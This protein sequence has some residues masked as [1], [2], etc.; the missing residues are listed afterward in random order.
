MFQTLLLLLNL[1]CGVLMVTDDPGAEDPS[2]ATEL[3]QD[4]V[5]AAIQKAIPLLQQGASVSAKERKC[6][7]CHNQALPVI[8]LTE[9]AKRGF[10][11]DREI[12]Q[13]QLQHTWDHLEKGKAEYHAGKGQ[14]GQVMTAGYAMW[15]LEAGAWEADET[16]AAVCHYLVEY[17]KD[18]NR[19]LPSSQRLPSMGSSFTATYVALRAL[20]HYGTSEQADSIK[21]RRDAAAKW[22]LENLPQ[23]NED[24]VFRLRTLPY[25]NAAEDAIQKDVEALL[26]IQQTDGGWSQ[27]D[28][29]TSDAYA[30]GTVLTALQEVGRLPVS[31]PAIVSG[32]R[33]LIDSQLEDGTW[34]V[35]THAKPIQTYY[36]S[37]FPHGPDQFISI[38]A[39]AW[40][41]LALAGTLPETT[42]AAEP[43]LIEVRRIWDRA[44]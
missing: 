6:F 25:L 12:L 33:Y 27:T 18:Q 37:G 13:R 17:H 34:H 36:E 26:A 22:F 40:A 5:R 43:E 42:G 19:W 2:P 24:R 15:A 21:A 38:T 9:F 31:H 8:A 32:C 1:A 44:Q 35:V 7:T 11:V 3:S 20:S 16:T 4:A 14:G 41:A 39:T 10:D 30:T 29:M 28:E 23:D